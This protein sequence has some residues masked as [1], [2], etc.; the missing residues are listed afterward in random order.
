MRTPTPGHAATVPVR[1]AP[2]VR[3]PPT[4]AGTYPPAIAAELPEERMEFSSDQSSGWMK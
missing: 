2:A 3:L 1:V 4:A